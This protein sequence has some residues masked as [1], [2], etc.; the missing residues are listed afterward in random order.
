MFTI[1]SDLCEGQREIHKFPFSPGNEGHC[2]HVWRA[3]FVEL[4]HSAWKDTSATWTELS[5]WKT[6]LN[7][8]LDNGPQMKWLASKATRVTW[9]H[10]LG[11]RKNRNGKRKSDEQVQDLGG[12]KKGKKGLLEGNDGFQKVLFRP[13]QPEKGAGKDSHQNNGRRKDRKRKGKEGAQFQSGFSASETPTEEGYAHAPGNQTIGLPVIGLTILGHQML[14]GVAQRLMLHGWWQLHWILPTVQRTLF[15]TLVAHGRL[16]R[17]RQSKDSRS[18]HGIGVSRRNSI[19]VTSLSFSPTRRQTLAWKVALST[20]Q[21]HHHVLP[22]LV[23]LGQ[24]TCPCCFTHSHEKLG[25]DFWTGSK[26][27]QYCTSSFW[28]V[29]S[30]C[31]SSPV[32]CSTVGHIVLDLTNLACQPTTKSWT[33]WSPEETC[34]LCNVRAKTSISSSAS[35]MEGTC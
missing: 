28:L 2:L 27:R 13:Y 29:L 21:Q 26:R 25:H 31:L 17:D 6:V 24:V 5:M 33:T 35:I 20:F 8:T 34:N 30:V 4:F 15:W 1:S 7:T 12:P 22:R 32:E 18:M 19:V 10:D 9:V 11:R 16:E 23:C 14:C 3:L